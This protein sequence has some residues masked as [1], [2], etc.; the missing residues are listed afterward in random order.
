MRSTGLVGRWPLDSD[1]VV[2]TTARDVGRN[3]NDGTVLTDNCSLTTGIHDEADGAIYSNGT[4]T[5]GE[6]KSNINSGATIVNTSNPWSVSLFVKNDSTTDDTFLVS[7]PKDN[8]GG[9]AHA[10]LGIYL[11]STTGK[12]IVFGRKSDDSGDVITPQSTTSTNDGAWHHIVGQYTGTHLEVYV[13]GTR[14]VN[15]DLAGQALRQGIGSFGICYLRGGGS[16]K[17]NGSIA[18]VLVYSYAL[19]AGQIANL[20][21]SYGV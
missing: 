9:W 19:T 1:T 2:G 10:C 18:K 11:V 21:Q 15:Y 12:I 7:L 3:G 8:W 4:C 17:F 16:V 13:D 14:E 5:G 20:Y 6:A